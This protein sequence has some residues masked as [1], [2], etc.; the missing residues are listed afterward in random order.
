MYYLLGIIVICAMAWL[1]SLPAQNDAVDFI[2]WR[3]QI[4]QLSGLLSTVLLS[5][6]LIFATRPSWI[7]QRLGGLDKLYLLHKK[8]GIA[9]C[10]MITIHWLL[11]KAPRYLSELGFI[12][13][14][15]HRNHG[16]IPWRGFMVDIGEIAFYGIVII[17]IISL[18]K[19]L[20]YNQFKITHKIAAIVAALALI[21]GAYL[22]TPALRWTSFG[23]LTWLTSA[24][25]FCAALFCLSGQIGKKHRF[26]GHIIAS[27]SLNDDVIEIDISAAQGFVEKYQ[28][29]QFALVTLDEKEGS[30]PFT[31]MKYDRKNSIL[32]FAIKK[33]GDYTG[34]LHASI[35]NGASV[36]VEGPYGRFILPSNSNTTTYWIAGGIGITPFIAW[37]EALVERNEKRP[38]TTLI[39]CVNNHQDLIFEEQLKRLTALC[40]ITLKILVQKQDGLLVPS[41]LNNY[42][43]SDYWFCGPIGMRKMLLANLPKNRI[44]FENFTFR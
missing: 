13:L 38:H 40:G 16:A 33:L 24:T 19:A 39:Y 42:Q 30:H 7:E 27:R 8:M 36:S 12:R 20:P 26:S 11:S 43:N 35:K 17:V 29:G 5:T 44:H 6:L 21:H 9:A 10:I 15:P 32:T 1:T 4:I 18:I 41:T 31:V 34:R 3:N 23:I 37:L 22:V 14:G 2:Y 28:P 25:G